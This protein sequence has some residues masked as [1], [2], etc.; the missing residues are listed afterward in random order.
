[1]HAAGERVPRCEPFDVQRER[2]VPGLPGPAAGPLGAGEHRDRPNPGVSERDA[3]ALDLHR[4]VHK[5]LSSSFGQPMESL[6]GNPSVRGA[7]QG[8]DRLRQL[9]VGV[10]RRPARPGTTRHDPVRA[11]QL[12]HLDG[13]NHGDRH[14]GQAELL[15]Q[16]AKAGELVG[17]RRIVPL[18]DRQ[19]R[20][21][22]AGDRVAAVR[23]PV[24]CHPARL[25]GLTGTVVLQR[26]GDEVVSDPEVVDGQFAESPGDR[27][28]R[29]EVRSGLPRW[30][31]RGRAR[32]DE[33][34]RVRRGQVVLLGPGRGGQHDVGQQGGAGHP[35]VQRDQQ[36]ELAFGSVIPPDHV[37]RPPIRRGLGRPQR[38]VR[39]EQVPQEVLVALQ[40]GAEQVRPPQG[41]YPGPV[42]RRVRVLG[43]EPQRAGS[44]RADDV[45]VRPLARG[46]DLVSEVERVAVELRVGRHPTQAGGLG[47]RVDG[48]H[49]GELAPRQRGGEHVGPVAVVT[50]LV[51]VGVPE[52][53]PDHLA[54]R[55][56]PVEAHRESGPAGDRPAPHRTGV[57]RPA[58]AGAADRTGEQQQRQDGPVGDVPV[59][60][61]ADPG[62][63]NDHVLAAGTLG[64]GGH[65]ARDPDAVPGRHRRQRLLPG[66]RVRPR[67]VVVPL[68][69][70]S[71]QAQAAQSILGEDQV[72]HGRDETATDPSHRDT[73]AQH[74]ARAV[75]AVEP[76]QQQVGR[77]DT[78]RVAVER[79][80]WDDPVE[81]E[82]PAAHPGLGVSEPERTVGHDQIAGPAVDEGG[83]PLLAFGRPA[84]RREIGGGEELRRQVA[85]GWRFR[86]GD[87]ERHVGEPAQVVGEERNLVVHKELTQ[88]HMAHRHRERAVGAG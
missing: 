24:P 58:T 14:G 21:G 46:G 66:R 82:V 19:R 25:G 27:G 61:L 47:D 38:R 18:D 45:G 80:L 77:A 52:R 31:G 73:P 71:R 10:Q 74:V 88:D 12:G 63:C 64:V 40:R 39:P 81:V 51:G 79:Q 20:H 85:A 60:P 29:R 36:I 57:G 43:G 3:S 17:D 87:Q 2:R 30:F 34:L 55:A 26:S 23:P 53:G 6:D 72:E 4:E 8:E 35:E 9:R 67:G 50:P 70:V 33:R 1:M 37:P 41:Q 65:L 15:D 59:K 84:A 62:P 28:E 48:V 16:R 13:R 56:G 75:R 11:G 69:P 68:R 5:G 54:R 86:E 83:L 76:G 32:L 78:A 44:D 42:L 7:G 22:L 49:A